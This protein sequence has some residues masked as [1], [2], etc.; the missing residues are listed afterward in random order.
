MKDLSNLCSLS[1]LLHLCTRKKKDNKIFTFSPTCTSLCTFLECPSCSSSD[2]ALT[3]RSRMND[4]ITLL[5]MYA[6]VLRRVT[7]IQKS[8]ETNHTFSVVPR[9]HLY[10][11]TAAIIFLY[12]YLFPCRTSCPKSSTCL[13][14]SDISIFLR[15]KCYTRFFFSDIS[16]FLNLYSLAMHGAMRHGFVIHGRCRPLSS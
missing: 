7:C 3:Q 2:S 4:S 6:S 10:S 1:K 9:A 16:I 12:I 5:R 14:F 13:F 8:I 15:R 11:R